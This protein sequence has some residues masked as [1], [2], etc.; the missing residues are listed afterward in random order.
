MNDICQ[1][2]TSTIKKSHGYTDIFLILC[3]YSLPTKRFSTNIHKT[4][5]SVHKCKSKVMRVTLVSD[6]LATAIRYTVR[7]GIRAGANRRLYVSTS[8]FQANVKA[9]HPGCGLL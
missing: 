7:A 4:S 6:A 5:T 8:W 9:T 2:D 1:G 3:L